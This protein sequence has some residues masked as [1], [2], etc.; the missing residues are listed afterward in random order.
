[1]K[2]DSFNFF[3]SKLLNST[4]KDL[5]Q[6]AYVLATVRHESGFEAIVER[7]S[8][9][10]LRSKPYYPYFWQRLY[11]LT[12]ETN[13]KRFGDLLGIDLVG[14]PDLACTRNIME[15]PRIRNDEKDYSLEETSDYFNETKTDWINARKI[16][17]D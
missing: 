4:I 9:K 2:Q 13:Y 17:N 12:W 1:M 3:L 14:N 8:E 15:N 10:Y 11:A 6:Q 16:I 7:G 5:H